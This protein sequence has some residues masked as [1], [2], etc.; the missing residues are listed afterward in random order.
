MKVK[1][2]ASR[3]ISGKQNCG[4]WSAVP[5]IYFQ[6]LKWMIKCKI[7]ISLHFLWEKD[8]FLL[9]EK[10]NCTQHQITRSN[11]NYKVH[12]HHQ[13]SFGHAIFYYRTSFNSLIF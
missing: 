1:Y 13:N 7:R 5:R 9:Y 6:F 11:N 10:Q 2:E 4:K 3:L 12:H 8:Q